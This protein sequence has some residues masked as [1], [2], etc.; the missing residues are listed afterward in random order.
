[1][2]RIFKHKAFIKITNILISSFLASLGM[3]A[4]TAWLF[5]V[6]GFIG[7]LIV[8]IITIFKKHLSMYT[9]PAYAIFEGLALG[10][11]SNIFELQTHLL[12][13]S[14]NPHIYQ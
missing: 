3:L 4:L 10:A 9:V 2:K 12:M 6:F 5:I 1:M 13:N 8:A 14:Y 11:I 7:G